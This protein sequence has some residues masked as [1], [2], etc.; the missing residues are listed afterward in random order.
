M[1]NRMGTV[2]E[3]YKEEYPGL[4]TYLQ[5]QS[6]AFVAGTM[7]L[8]T[9]GVGTYF[10]QELVKNYLPWTK[11]SFILPAIAVGSVLSYKITRIKTTACQEMWIAMEDRRTYL[12]RL[13]EEGDNVKDFDRK[14]ALDAT[15]DTRV[16]DDEDDEDE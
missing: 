8:A 13:G 9:G 4:P 15:R 16:M 12:T 3:D 1:G 14:K 2:A 10:A 6:S 11:K 7:A 5:C